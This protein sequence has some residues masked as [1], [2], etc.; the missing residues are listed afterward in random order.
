MREAAAKSAVHVVD[1][2][3]VEESEEGGELGNEGGT[4]GEEFR[5]VHDA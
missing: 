3:T 4:K 1:A 2:A 5:R